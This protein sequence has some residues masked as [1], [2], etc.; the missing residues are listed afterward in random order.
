MQRDLKDG[1]NGWPVGLNPSYPYCRRLSSLGPHTR[2]AGRH[3]HGKDGVRQ[4]EGGR[5]ENVRISYNPDLF[6]FSRSDSVLPSGALT[7]VGLVG[8]R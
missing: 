6:S 1:R 5:S 4:G 8:D 3:R 7:F 2:S